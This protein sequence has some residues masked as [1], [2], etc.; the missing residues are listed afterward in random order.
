MY[1]VSKIISWP[2]LLFKTIMWCSCN[3]WDISE[4]LLEIYIKY[5]FFH[6]SLFPSCKHFFFFFCSKNKRLE[7]TISWKRTSSDMSQNWM[8]SP[9][10]FFCSYCQG[11]RP[12]LC[13]SHWPMCML[14]PEMVLWP[15]PA[16]PVAIYLARTSRKPGQQENRHLL[17]HCFP[18]H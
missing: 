18:K 2:I 5:T 15:S 1:P 4:I 7:I 17:P 14:E 12:L 8:N 11:K 13:W 6:Y 10:S 16:S 3:Q 9:W